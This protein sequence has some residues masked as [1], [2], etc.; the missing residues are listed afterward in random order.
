MATFLNVHHSYAI[1]VLIS[2]LETPLYTKFSPKKPKAYSFY[3]V[4]V[5]C[6]LAQ[7]SPSE[8]A[9]GNIQSVCSSVRNQSI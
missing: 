7:P 6:D 5:S 2:E 8:Q 1:L 9:A 4:P 3:A